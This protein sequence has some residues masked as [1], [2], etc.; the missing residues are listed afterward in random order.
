[1]LELAI[2]FNR[3]L[4][5]LTASEQAL[6]KQ[7]VFDYMANPA[8]PGLSPHPVDRARDKRFWTIRVGVDL[9]VV[10]FKEGTRSLFC[11]I[12]HHDD[13]YRWAEG[14]CF[15]VHPITGL[16]RLSNS[17]KS[18]ETKYALSRVKL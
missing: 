12:G 16:R 1:M 3:S 10:L 8:R 15:E 11:Y 9:R 4:G 5:R 6:A 17:K 18:S 2:T 14:R 13:A 7:V